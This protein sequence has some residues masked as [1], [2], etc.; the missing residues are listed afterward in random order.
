MKNVMTI[1]VF[2]HLAVGSQAVN[3]D[4]QDMEVLG[5][6]P[7]ASQQFSSALS[8]TQIANEL[9]FNAAPFDPQYHRRTA[10]K[11]KAGTV[12]IFGNVTNNFGNGVCGLV[13]ANGNFMFSCTPTGSYSLTTGLDGNGQVTLFSFADGHFPFKTVLGGS[14][15]RYDIIMNVASSAPPPLQLSTITFTITDACHDG[16]AID[17]RFWDETNGLVWP[18]STTSYF[19]Q[20]DDT[21][22]QSAL[23]C[24]TG[25]LICYGARDA[26]PALPIYWGVDVDNSKSCADCCIRCQSGNSLNR[27][28]TCS[29]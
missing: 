27:R 23:S 22:Y 2:V 5:Y 20:F 9:Q 11:P 28:L 7:L 26:N 6:Q 29:I 16:W 17:Y 13:L 8:S 21:P 24:E 18:S 1:L 4:G 10:A 3:A 25:A 15:G 14:G 12:S 19:S